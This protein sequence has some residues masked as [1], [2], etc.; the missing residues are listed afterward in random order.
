VARYPKEDAALGGTAH[1]DGERF[2]G[3]AEHVL[4]HEEEA[5][6]MGTQREDHSQVGVDQPQIDHQVV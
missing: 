4:A 6:R 1:P 2:L 5:E 3:D